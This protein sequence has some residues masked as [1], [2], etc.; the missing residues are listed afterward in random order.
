VSELPNKLWKVGE[1]AAATG[2]TVRA[3]HHY[4]ELGLLVP[5]QRTFAGYRLY[6]DG[7]VRRLYRIVALRGLGLRLDQIAETLDGDGPDLDQTVSRQIEA[8][9]RRLDEL[10][11][12]HERLRAIRDMLD[13][14]EQPSID[15]LIT[16]MEAIAMH[17]KYYTPEQLQRL[18]GRGDALGEEA[19]ENAQRDWSEIYAGLR[20]EMHAGTDPADLKLDHYRERARALLRAFTGGDPD[21]TASLNRMWNNED[22]EKVSRGMIDRELADYANRTFNA[23]QDTR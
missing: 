11:Q 14:A 12:L 16:T 22:P 20:A 17:E 9:E 13:R 4:G 7:D 3:L 18:R 5:S 10:G 19:I 2:L 21:I 1:L 15:Q 8:V 6:D 23:P